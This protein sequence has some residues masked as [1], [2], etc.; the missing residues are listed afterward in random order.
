[1]SH[2]PFILGAYAATFVGTVGLAGWSWLAMR[3]SEREAG[4]LRNEP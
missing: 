2:W 1:M 3:R 4:R